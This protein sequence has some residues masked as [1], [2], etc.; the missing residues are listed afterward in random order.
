MKWNKSN[1]RILYLPALPSLSVAISRYLNKH[2]SLVHRR[3]TSQVGHMGG[4]AGPERGRRDGDGSRVIKSAGKGALTKSRSV[5]EGRLTLMAL[6]GRAQTPLISNQRRFK[7]FKFQ[8]PSFRS[9][10]ESSSPSPCPTSHNIIEI[11]LLVAG[12]AP[13]QPEC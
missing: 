3:D 8:R 1:R 9:I 11:L 2:R 13:T 12:A 7:D 4:G 5:C 6:Y 10:F